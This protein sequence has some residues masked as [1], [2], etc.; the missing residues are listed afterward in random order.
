MV[1]YLQSLIES[2][3]FTYEAVIKLLEGVGTNYYSLEHKVVASKRHHNVVVAFLDKLQKGLG[4]VRMILLPPNIVEENNADAQVYIWVECCPFCRLGFE[5]LWARQIAYCKHAYHVW[6]A[7]AHFSLSIKCIDIFCW[8]D[9]RERWW[10][11]TISK[12][13]RVSFH[14]HNS[15]KLPNFK[16]ARYAYISYL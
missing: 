13:P 7:H 16:L 6:C 2:G 15:N 5:P 12:S 9:M 4:L 14:F 3:K 11:A 8:E 10:V 1:D